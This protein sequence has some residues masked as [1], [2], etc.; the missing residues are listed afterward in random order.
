MD[1]KPVD[2]QETTINL[3]HRPDRTAYIWTENRRWITRLKRLGFSADST[4]KGP[5]LW[6][7]IP[8]RAIWL[9]NPRRRVASEAQKA[10]LARLNP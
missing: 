2:Y 6:F 9:K 3:I 1:H 7:R 5:G 8:E 4:R 10:N